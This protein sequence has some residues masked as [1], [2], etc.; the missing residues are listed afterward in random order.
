MNI[1]VTG[2]AG[3]IG[4]AYIRNNTSREDYV[5]CMDKLTY[6]G[7]IKNL[8]GLDNDYVEFLEIDISAPFSQD[9]VQDYDLIINFAAESHVDRSIVDA[10]DFLH[11]AVQGVHNLLEGA[12]KSVRKPRFVQVSTDE[13]YGSVVYPAKEGDNLNPSSP[14][15]AAKA[16]SELLV[17]SYGKTYGID[18]VITRGSNTFGP[19]QYP[20]K[21]IPVLIHQLVS[22]RPM[23]LYGNGGNRR[24]WIYVDDHATAIDFVARNGES[25]NIYNIG[26]RT[27]LSNIEIAEMLSMYVNGYF[28][29]VDFV[30]DRLGHDESYLMDCSK[31]EKLGWKSK[32]EFYSGLLTTI[33]WYKKN[34]DWFER[35]DIS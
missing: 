34:I 22:G 30:T 16:A 6:A 11:T 27:H 21:L 29:P 20:E 17:Q 31:L 7:N 33:D 26:G 12:R 3:F 2:G 13:V 24:Q 9:I 10:T 23:T 25:G 1:L 19:H 14:Y 18:Y 32:T 8:N 35:E 28:A 4:S 15:S 5:A